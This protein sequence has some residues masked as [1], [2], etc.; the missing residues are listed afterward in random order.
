MWTKP[1]LTFSLSR[2][3]T[4]W[5]IC[6]RTRLVRWVRPVPSSANRWPQILTWLSP[7]L[8]LSLPTYRQWWWMKRA[9]TL[10]GPPLKRLLLIPLRPPMTTRLLPAP[11]ATSPN[12]L[13]KSCSWKRRKRRRLRQPKRRTLW[14]VC[15]RGRCKSRS[16]KERRSKK[17]RM[18]VE[19]HG[20]VLSS[21]SR[22]PINS[23][24]QSSVAE[25]RK[26]ATILLNK[27][28][29]NLTRNRL[30]RRTR[31]YL[32]AIP[33]SF[34]L[35]ALSWVQSL[36]WLKT[37]SSSPLARMTLKIWSVQLSLVKTPPLRQTMTT[38]IRLRQTRR[39]K[40]TTLMT[41]KN[42]RSISII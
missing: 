35:T 22:S 4:M 37:T 31:M 21:K 27:L 11:P 24:T 38:L 34:K 28:L 2:A 12:Q 14:E 23:T 9:Q 10:Q 5:P 30:K 42:L 19:V 6:D 8:Q 17:S 40:M 29:S 32:R 16:R 26:T 25:R 15:S 13:R 7:W 41:M 3:L 1:L 20:D 18:K 33:T 39:K 36:T